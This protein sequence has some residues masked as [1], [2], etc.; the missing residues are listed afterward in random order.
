ME[1]TNSDA[2]PS[3]ID[4]EETAV[5]CAVC[6]EPIDLRKFCVGWDNWRRLAHPDCY[7]R[8]RVLASGSIEGAA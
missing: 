1:I 5:Q 6:G 8:G 4:V 3:F 2:I 7:S